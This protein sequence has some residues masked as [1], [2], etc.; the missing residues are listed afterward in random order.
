MASQ[1]SVLRMHLSSP[2]DV[3]VTDM[4]SRMPT[5]L[6]LLTSLDICTA[7]FLRRFNILSDDGTQHEE[8][9]QQFVEDDFSGLT[10]TVA[11]G[12]S[13]TRSTRGLLLQS[14]LRFGNPART[15]C[16]LLYPVLTPSRN[17][18]LLPCFVHRS[19]EWHLL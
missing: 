16:R 6:H 14:E 15:Q 19:N 12:F 4:P 10:A 5:A 2:G 17:L 1:L 11:S 13:E 18:R 3:S 8:Y 9:M 7:N